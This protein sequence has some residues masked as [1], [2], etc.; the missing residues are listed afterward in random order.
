M[1][2]RNSS[3]LRVIAV[4]AAALLASCNTLDR[5]TEVGGPPKTSAIDDPTKAPGYKPVDLPMP[6]GSA[7]QPG[8][9]SL[10]RPGARDF[11]KDL[12]ATEV[13]DIITV[14]INMTDSATLKNNTNAVSANS[15]AANS[16]FTFFGYENSLKHVLPST[17]NPAN[18][19]NFGSN[20]TVNGTGTLTRQETVTVDM[21]AVVT[22]KLP[23]GNLVLSGTQELRVNGE[24]RQLSVKGIIRPQDIASNNT[25]SSDQ[26]AEARIVYGGR[27][28]L[29]DVQTARWGQQL[30]DILMPF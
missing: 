12:R 27:G 28:T 23:N 5:L 16:N 8:P 6:A 4:A 14:V 29:S 17:V 22:Q 25:I 19:F 7:P 10:W 11:F 13:G 15:D 20:S 2:A 1:N 9:N 24:L 21:A 26:I 30:F 18:L 3:S